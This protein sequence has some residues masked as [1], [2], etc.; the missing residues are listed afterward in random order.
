MK[1]IKKLALLF[2]ILT[3]FA[4]SCQ[5]A[6]KALNSSFDIV[7]DDKT[8]VPD[9]PPTPVKG[10][11]DLPADF[12]ITPTS[13]SSEDLATAYSGQSHEVRIKKGSAVKSYELKTQASFIEHTAGVANAKGILEAIELKPSYDLVDKD[14][15]HYRLRVDSSMFNALGARGHSA[16]IKL[17]VYIDA[18]KTSGDKYNTG[19]KTL[20]VNVKRIK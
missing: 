4:I 16:K 19:I 7:T 14:S 12:T 17:D 8:S 20:Y 18:Q 6:Q 13:F 11:E 3:V 9:N 2:S 10:G 5:N 15:D 1:Q